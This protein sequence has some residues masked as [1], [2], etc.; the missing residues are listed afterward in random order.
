ME[1]ARQLLTRV[2]QKIASYAGTDPDLQRIVS[3]LRD[4]VEAF[5]G[6]MDALQAKQRHFASYAAQ[7]SRTAEGKSRKRQ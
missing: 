3:E 2:A 7:H 6:H 4:D 5:A 1:E